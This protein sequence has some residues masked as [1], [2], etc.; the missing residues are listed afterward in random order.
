MSIRHP[1]RRQLPAPVISS[2]SALSAHEAERTELAAQLAEFMASG[3][4]VEPLTRGATADKAYS[5]SN[6]SKE[7]P[8]GR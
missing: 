8:H 6:R 4:I 3:G 1:E 2:G 7:I 5:F